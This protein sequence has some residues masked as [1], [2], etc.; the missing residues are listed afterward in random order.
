MYATRSDWRKASA[1]VENAAA[2]TKITHIVNTNEFAKSPT[3]KNNARQPVSRVLSRTIIYL[4]QWSP[5]AS[6]D[7]PKSHASNMRA[8]SRSIFGLA[9]D[10]VYP[11]I[12]VTSDAVRSY[13]T[14]S[15]LP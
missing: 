15:P 10:G 12:T 1:N 2:P 6:C 4:E 9:P 13:R 5:I 3:P 14:F 7:L 8:N 11:A